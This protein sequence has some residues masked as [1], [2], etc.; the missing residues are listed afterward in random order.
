L[1]ESI[2][3]KCS[4]NPFYGCDHDGTISFHLNR[5]QAIEI[6]DS[7]YSGLSFA[8]IPDEGYKAIDETQLAEYLVNRSY[9]L[10]DLFHF[11]IGVE[12]KTEIF[13]SLSDFGQP[14]LGQFFDMLT[15]DNYKVLDF[16]GDRKGNITIDTIYNAKWLSQ[17]D[18]RDRSALRTAEFNK[19]DFYDFPFTF[20]ISYEEIGGN[21]VELESSADHMA[22]ALYNLFQNRNEIFNH[23][24]N[25]Q[26][27]E[28]VSDLLV[29]LIQTKGKIVNPMLDGSISRFPRTITKEECRSRLNYLNERTSVASDIQNRFGRVVSNLIET[30]AQGLFSGCLVKALTR[31]LNENCLLGFDLARAYNRFAYIY[32]SDRVVLF[33][34]GFF[35]LNKSDLGHLK[36]LGISS[37]RKY[38]SENSNIIYFLDGSTGN[39]R[40]ASRFGAYPDNYIGLTISTLSLIGHHPDGS[41]ITTFKQSNNF[42]AIPTYA[43]HITTDIKYTP[44]SLLDS[45]TSLM[46]FSYFD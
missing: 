13:L 3:N 1:N 27:S 7:G 35:E 20:S 23:S 2:K 14:I 21:I 28:I 8:V 26:I 37:G 34:D 30:I 42:C 24:T 32:Q 33:R 41:S 9:N 39:I 18:N 46:N 12:V 4:L 5:D 15:W 29:P 31:I 22:D 36:V 19:Y 43:G 11:V 44:I 10:A 45:N 25:V 38:Y 6:L 40:K 16:L 17:F